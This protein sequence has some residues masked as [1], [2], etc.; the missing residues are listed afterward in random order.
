MT[1][2]KSTQSTRRDNTKA[3]E[4]TIKRETEKPSAARKATVHEAP[5]Q[6]SI[7]SSEFMSMMGM[8]GMQFTRIP[9]PKT[10]IISII[11]QLAVIAVGATA[12]GYIAAY[13]AVGA[14]MLGAGMFI[15]ISLYYFA[16]L[17]GCLA[18]VYAGA[19][20]GQWIVTGRAADHMEA[21][22]GWVKRKFSSASSAIK[23]RMSWERSDGATVH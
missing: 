12:A 1:A 18:A 9:T 17:I 15:A 19:K 21:A 23:Q 14:A 16:L 20:V 8:N 10:V 2:R 3:A 13:L 22:G 5:A 4:A 7:F 6:E 11:A